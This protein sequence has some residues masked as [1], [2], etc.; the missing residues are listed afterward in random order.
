MMKWILLAFLG[1]IIVIVAALFVVP[2]MI[3]WKPRLIA[4]VRASTGRELRIDGP[5]RISIFPDIRVAAAGIHF[6]NAPG[7]T[8]PEMVSVGSLKLEVALW[9]LI[10]HHIVVRSLIIQ[11]PA[12]DL[13]VDKNGRGNWILAPG[14]GAA[15]AAPGAEPPKPP[16][17]AA[18]AQLR[19]DRFEIENGRVT[20]RNAVTGQTLRAADVSLKAAMA[21]AALPLRLDGRMILNDQPVT[22][23]LSVDSPALL[24]RGKEAKVKLALDARTLTARFDGGAQARPVPGLNGTFDLDVSSVGQLLAWLQRPLPKSQPDPGP[25]KLHAVFTAHGARSELKSL[26]LTGTGL[27]AKASGSLDASG[28]VTKIALDIESGVLQ[29]DRYLPPS[30]P[31]A[32]AAPSVQPGQRQAPL[33]GKDLMAEVSDRPFDLKALRGADANIKIAIAGIQGRGQAIG[34]ITFTALAKKGVI[35]ANLSQVALYG[36]DV[37]GLLKLDASGNALGLD[38]DLKINHV[39]IDRAAGPQ[40]G[41]LPISGTITAALQAKASGKSPRALAESLQGR[42]ALDLGDV[43]ARGPGAPTFSQAKVD[44]EIPGPGKPSHLAASLVYKAERVSADATLAPLNKLLS[45]ARAPAKLALDSKL[46]TLR[47][48]GALQSRPIAAADGTLDLDIPSVAK[49]ASWVGRPLDPKRPDP[50]PLKLHAVLTSDGPKLDL[51]TLAITGK[52]IKATAS[53]RFADAKKLAT[54]DAKV[55]VEDADLNAY[56]PPPAKGATAAKPAQA[57]AKAATGWSTAPFDV[58]PLGRANGQ[59]VIRLKKVRYRDLDIA[60]GTVKI[61]L[62]NRVLKFAADKTE[63]A[64]GTL[65]GSATLDASGSVPKLDYQASASGI[66]ARP[67]LQT[68]ADSGRLSGTVAFETRGQASGRSERAL[69]DG[70]DGSGRFKITNGAIHGINLAQALRKVGT[71]GFGASQTEKTDFAELSGSYTIKSGIIDNR[72]LKMLA[73]LVRLTGAGTVPMPPQT[74]DYTI[75]A[76]LVPTIKGQGG[77]DALAGLP[78]PIKI[79]GPWRGPSYKVD[80][81]NVFQTMAKDPARLKNLPAN[82]AQA[83]KGFGVNLPGA[84]GLGGVLQNLPGSPATAPPAPT[85]PGTTNGTQT[86][87]VPSLPSL[88]KLFGQ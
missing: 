22:A 36:G 17:S 9:P 15:T 19:I 44:L 50:G 5:L 77:Q 7:L 48:D 73:P 16:E 29:L 79:T 39:R 68:F 21:D 27:N 8:P 52:A 69:V 60:N 71:L 61:T 3:D 35:T 75:E 53:G 70:L 31:A 80:W 49:L 33:P 59:A 83:A 47:Y 6:A 78:I 56:L 66:Q 62:A 45:G 23:S 81:A 30:A 64:Q 11:N 41:R 84:G 88:K 65:S 24:T 76:K 87:P 26:T 55:D 85:T 20:Y 58:T 13:E 40:A 28:P 37:K 18:L 43:K 42:L 34:P 14:R 86:S 74:V 46:F 38:T 63:L 82:L 1:L 10:S 2:S 54:F 67:L 25:V 51:K 12:V 57:T 4:A 72:D 32:K